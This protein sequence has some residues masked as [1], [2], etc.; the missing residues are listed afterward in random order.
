VTGALALPTWN[1]ENEEIAIAMYEVTASHFAHEQNVGIVAQLMDLASG[2]SRALLE[3]LD[4]FRGAVLQLSPI[5]RASILIKLAEPR[6]N[7]YSVWSWVQLQALLLK[8]LE[9]MLINIDSFS[10]S[11]LTLSTQVFQTETPP[12]RSYMLCFP[13]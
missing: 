5:E 7:G 3:V 13:S 1:I 4:A 2:S 12:Q 9:R 11:P 10:W 8:W 6:Q